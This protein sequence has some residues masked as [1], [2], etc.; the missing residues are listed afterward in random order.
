MFGTRTCNVLRTGLLTATVIGLSLVGGT[1]AA[2]PVDPKPALS[3]YDIVVNPPTAGSY[4]LTITTGTAFAIPTIPDGCAS[5]SRLVEQVLNVEQEAAAAGIAPLTRSVLV[6]NLGELDADAERRITVPVHERI[7]GTRTVTVQLSSAG[8]PVEEMHLSHDPVTVCA[9][10][11]GAP[12]WRTD[13]SPTDPSSAPAMTVDVPARG[14][15]GGTFT[16]STTLVLTGL[17]VCEQNISRTVTTTADGQF[18]FPGLLP[19]RYALLDEHGA[20]LTHVDLTA[21]DLDRTGMEPALP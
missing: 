9:P 5:E 14:R 15:I 10:P 17:D 21:E 1:A 2:D 8:L 20:V 4:T 19:G 3:Q 16:P 18:L 6:C 11:D 13:T 7:S 12:T